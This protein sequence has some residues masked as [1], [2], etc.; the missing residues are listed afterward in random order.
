[1]IPGLCFGIVIGLA[2][3]A[4]LDGRR[5]RPTRNAEGRLEVL[6]GDYEPKPGLTVLGRRPQLFDQ[7]KEENRG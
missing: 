6:L 3:S 2:L 4:W 1:M 7:E 5:R